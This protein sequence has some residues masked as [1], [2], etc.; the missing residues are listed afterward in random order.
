[1]KKIFTFALS[2]MFMLG[3]GSVFA[4]EEED[5]T[6]YIVNAGFDE[7]LTWNAD[8]SKKQATA[9]ETKSLS[10][11]SNAF[12]AADG[13]LYATVASTTD[14]KRSDGR[15][16]EA[17]NGFVGQIKGWE[18]V[19]LNNDGAVPLDAT[20]YPDLS[21]ENARVESK[22]CEW[23]YFGTVAYGLGETAI[24]VADDGA[25]YLPGPTVSTEFDYG[26]GALHLRA[27]WG[28]SFAYKQTV[29]LPCAKYRLEYWTINVNPNTTADGTDLTQIICRRD[30]FKETDTEG[31]SMK[32]TK[33]TKHEFEFTPTSEFTLIFG[34]KAGDG[35]SGAT[36]WVYIDGIKLYK[37]DEADPEELLM[38][39]ILAES[40]DIMD[41]SGSLGDY[42]GL[43]GEISDA[44]D[45]AQDAEGVEAMTEAYKKLQALRAKLADLTALA[46]EYQSLLENEVSAILD[47]DNPYP[48]YDDFASKAEEIQ[49]AMEEEATSETFADYVA[50]LKKAINLYYTSQ[51]ASKENP[52][53]YTF[54]V[55]NPTFVEQGKWYIGQTGGDQRL[56]KE[57]TD[58][59]GNSIME[60]LARQPHIHSTVC[61]D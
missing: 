2:A 6:N 40:E 44:I 16:F 54:L 58:N 41:L 56:H 14:K 52:A 5:M 57:L 22:A 17:T 60:R 38:S 42:A 31:K 25:T 36:P 8:G 28:N 27:G 33:W 46:E 53:D 3:G 10:T 19:Y 18:W 32:N 48:G 12:I 13:S 23:V 29:K 4:Q 7:D 43:M 35:G 45:E 37:I 11:R 1:M 61:V 20:G 21:K 24:P 50:Q 49:A 15:T 39:D 51:E 9:T 30:V 34:F 26:T 55:D 59:D 47:T